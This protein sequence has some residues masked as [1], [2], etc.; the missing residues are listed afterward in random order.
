M[1]GSG[2]VK[3]RSPS[4]GRAGVEAAAAVEGASLTWLGPHIE[5]ASPTPC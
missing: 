3:L 2:R 4:I 1:Q 5:T